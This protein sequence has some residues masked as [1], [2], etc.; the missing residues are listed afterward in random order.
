MRTRTLNEVAARRQRGPRRSTLIGRA[1]A[2]AAVGVVGAALYG[3]WSLFGG[4]FVLVAAAACL[5][6]AVASS[7][8][9]YTALAP[10]VW[11]PLTIVVAV[12]WVG[13]VVGAVNTIKVGDEVYPSWS[14]K[15]H[16]HRD[17]TLLRDALGQLTTADVMATYDLGKVRGELEEFTAATLELRTMSERFRDVTLSDVQLTEAARAVAVAADAAAQ[18]VDLHRMLALQYST[19]DAQERD[20][21]RT[22]AISEALRAGRLVEDATRRAGLP[23]GVSE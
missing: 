13:A 14:P 21:L 3:T 22:T 5:L 15:A 2:S 19:R 10:S 23:R 11:L 16:V 20:L 8:D 4:W 18:A 7:R 17:A 6:A 9:L 12:A 1:V